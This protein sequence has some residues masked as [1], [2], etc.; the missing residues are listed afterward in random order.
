M[1][2]QLKQAS[3]KLQ[4]ERR[5]GDGVMGRDEG[6]ERKGWSDGGEGME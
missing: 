1:G 3:K 4:E 6:D 5:G 2:V